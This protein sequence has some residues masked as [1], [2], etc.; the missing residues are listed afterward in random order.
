MWTVPRYLDIFA[1][2]PYGDL[3]G[4][5]RIKIKGSGE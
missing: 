4:L 1:A 3:Y 5:S 2:T